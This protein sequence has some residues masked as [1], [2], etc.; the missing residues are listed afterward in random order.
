MSL[1]RIVV[2]FLLEGIEKFKQNLNKIRDAAVGFGDAGAKSAQALVDQFGAVE[3]GAE[4]IA[5][6]IEQGRVVTD[7]DLNAMSQAYVRLTSEIESAFGS[8]EAAPAEIQQAFQNAESQ[9]GAATAVV[10]GI[11]RETEKA[12]EKFRE[13]ADQATSTGDALTA[14]ADRGVAAVNRLTPEQQKVAD[15]ID[16]WKRGLEDYDKKLAETGD[17]GKRDVDKLT[18]AK[19][20]L[21]L[22]IERTGVQVKELGDEFTEQ[23]NRLEKETKE[24]TETV[25]QLNTTVGLSADETRGAAAGFTSFGQALQQVGGQIGNVTSQLTL[26]GG[27]LT[28]G[29]AIG[30]QFNKSIGTDMSEMELVTE[31]VF[32]RIG[33]TVTAWTDSLI[34]Q[35]LLIKAVY[36]LNWD[37]VKKSGENFADAIKRIYKS[38]VTS[39]QELRDERRAQDEERRRVDEARIKAEA[40]VTI[41]TDGTTKAIDKQVAAIKELLPEA[42]LNTLR[43]REQSAQLA[44]LVNNTDN[45]NDVERE[46]FEAIIKKTRAVHTLTEDE[47]KEL[48]KELGKVGTVQKQWT[49]GIQKFETATGNAVKRAVIPLAGGMGLV[50]IAVDETTE[51]TIDM[52]EELVEL[53]I[54]TPTTT[55]EVGK[56]EQGFIR[57]TTA[58]RDT[59]EAL[60]AA[61]EAMEKVKIQAA[62]AAGEQ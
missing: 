55:E 23:M 2:G 54:K 34:E 39:G 57:L 7:R 13:L 8:L 4:K 50:K 53:A 16:R 33:N 41:A 11:T 30:N 43:I 12:K 19:E 3:A 49:D 47:L 48:T 15:A 25:A 17:V 42:D 40:A 62:A 44:K 14:S 5:Q 32:L 10:Q 59:K 38:V 20:L 51:L 27:A 26:F 29:M 35:V 46:N 58:S 9:I 60:E 61:A 22:E 52:I 56:L 1:K 45:L 6:K 28:A 21:R 24:A 31:G 18:K 37:E 36:T